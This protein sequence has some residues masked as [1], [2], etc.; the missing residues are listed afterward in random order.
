MDFARTAPAWDPLG[1]PVPQDM[2][3]RL[4]EAEA[5]A[6]TG[7]ATPWKNKRWLYFCCIGGALFL[8]GG[9]LTDILALFGVPRDNVVI[10]ILPWF[11][12]F[13]FLVVGIVLAARETA[14]QRRAELLEKLRFAKAHGWVMADA[15]RYKE[16]RAAFPAFMTARGS[17]TRVTEEWWGVWKHGE[18]EYPVWL[19]DLESRVSTGSKS[20]RLEYSAIVGVKVRSLAPAAVS[21]VPEDM[22]H[23]LLQFFRGEYKTGNAEFDAAFHVGTGDAQQS[24]SSVPMVLNPPFMAAVMQYRSLSATRR[25][26]VHRERDLLLI[27]HVSTNFLENDPMLRVA[28]D[29]GG[30]RKADETLQAG[31]QKLIEPVLAVVEKAGI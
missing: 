30:V 16:L 28:A 7:D 11:I 21:L 13:D 24:S 19:A 4:A 12:G 29:A 18:R 3:R 15:N 5:A 25:V 10:M 8:F 26:Y 1:S 20:S 22:G 9:F 31:L 23:R 14:K 17:G 6:R 2:D 27:R